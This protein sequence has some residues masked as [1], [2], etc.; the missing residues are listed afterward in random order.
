MCPYMC[1]S[2]CPYNCPFYP[3]AQ[4]THTHTHTHRRGKHRGGASET[5]Y[6]GVLINGRCFQIPRRSRKVHNPYTYI[7]VYIYVYIHI[8][9][10]IFIYTYRYRGDPARY[11]IRTLERECLFGVIMWECLCVVIM[12]SKGVPFCKG[13]PLCSNYV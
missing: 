9:T 8:Y 12:C 6:F 4:H 1:L 7:Y 5:V 11:I 10:Y 13:V 2:M 3:S